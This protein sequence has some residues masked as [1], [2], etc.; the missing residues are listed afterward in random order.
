MSELFVPPT[1]DK[2]ST[3]FSEWCK[4]TANFMPTP[5]QAWDAQIQYIKQLEL[6]IIEAGTLLKTSSETMEKLKEMFEENLL[7]MSKLEIENMALKD[8]ASE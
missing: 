2:P 4:Q 7:I 5:E 3:D 1:D 6:R 8:K